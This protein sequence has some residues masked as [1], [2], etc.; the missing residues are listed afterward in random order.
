MQLIDKLKCSLHLTS[1]QFIKIFIIVKYLY[2]KLLTYSLFFSSAQDSNFPTDGTIIPI[3]GPPGPTGAPGQPG[4]SG[5]PGRS[6]PQGPIG[7]RGPRGFTGTSG[8]GRVSKSSST[9]QSKHDLQ[10]KHD[11]K[12]H[13]RFLRG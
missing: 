7:D 5:V 2:W 1:A 10:K 13:F 4:R 6:G 8:D 3:E 12:K 11:W 9:A